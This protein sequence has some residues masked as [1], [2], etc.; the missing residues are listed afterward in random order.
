MRSRLIETG[1][2]NR[3]LIAT[4]AIWSQNKHPQVKGGFI[5]IRTAPS[6]VAGYKLSTLRRSGRYWVRGAQGELAILLSVKRQLK[7]AWPATASTD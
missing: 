6:C 7:Q 5:A 4:P 3:G 1:D 2:P